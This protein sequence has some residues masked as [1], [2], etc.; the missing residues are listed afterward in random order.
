[1][2]TF[3]TLR[4]TANTPLRDRRHSSTVG[5]FED[6]DAAEM[7]RISLPNAQLLEVVVRE[8]PSPGIRP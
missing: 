6:F 7:A 5:R 2:T 8:I 3:H 1:M 4:Y